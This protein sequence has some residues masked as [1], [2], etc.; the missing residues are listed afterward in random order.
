MAL[1]LLAGTSLAFNSGPAL[2]F[3]PRVAGA[4]RFAARAPLPF[5]VATAPDLAE[6]VGVP[7]G[8]L[9]VGVIKETQKL[10]NRCAQS[11]QSAGSLAK[12]GFKVVVEKGAGVAAGFSDEAYEAE[13][14]TIVPNADAWK[15]DI[16]IKLNPPTSAELAKLQDRTIISLLNPAKNEDLLAQLQKQKATAFA[17]DMIP[18][19]LSRGQ[20][21]DV[22]SSQTNIIGYRA[23]VEAQNVFGRFFAGQMTAAGK[24]PP[25]KVLVLGAG[26]AGLAAIQAAK[27]AGAD[28]RAYDV[29]PAVKEQVESLGGKFL[30]VPYEEDGSGAP[31]RAAARLPHAART[32]ESCCASLSPLCPSDGPLACLMHTHLRLCSPVLQAR[33]D[34]P[35]RCRT[36]TRRRSRPC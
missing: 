34:M 25:A 15:S 2:R 29:R 18:R 31:P 35:R 14:A 22:L 19:M 27:N 10:E 12:A 36:A 5:N 33:A 32:L 1:M 11:P 9:T 17:L 28:V 24:V 23:V 7:Y 16:V 21:F 20:T 26:V 3:S 30:K 4:Q 6:R 8:D 13:G